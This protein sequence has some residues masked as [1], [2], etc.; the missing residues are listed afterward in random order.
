[1]TK[2]MMTQMPPYSS[3]PPGLSL[4]PRVRHQLSFLSDACVRGMRFRGSGTVLR[5]GSGA[6]SLLRES[7][8]VFRAAG[9]WPIVSAS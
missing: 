9:I 5:S 1:M 6:Y 8:Q 3:N 7:D 2:S 4:S